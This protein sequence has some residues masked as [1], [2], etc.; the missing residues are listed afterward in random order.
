MRFDVIGG[1]AL[2][3]V[4]IRLT[5]S[6]G[7]AVRAIRRLDG[8]RS[9]RE[10]ESFRLRD[11]TTS[12]L[13]DP[14]TGERLY[15]VW[16]TPDTGF[17]AEV[18]AALLVHEAVHVAQDYFREFGEEAPGEEAEAYVVQDIA[19]YLIESHF[20]WKRRRIARETE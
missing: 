1:G 20:E 14:A 8:E 12:F 4:Q 19:Q 7:K 16:M 11:A 6:K 9:A 2:P 10:W 3:E 15:L 5:H 18:D 17:S 13:R